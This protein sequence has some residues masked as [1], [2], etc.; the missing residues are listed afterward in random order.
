MKYYICAKTNVGL[1]RENNEDN[2]CINGTYMLS[3]EKEWGAETAAN[4][5]V[6]AVCDGMG[7]EEF[8]EFASLCAASNIAENCTVL[9]NAK[10][11]EQ[12]R[13]VDN[14]ISKI[15]ALICDEMRKRNVRI[16]STVTM[17]CIKNGVAD[18]YNIGDSRIYLFRNGALSQL[19]KDHTYFQQKADMGIK[20]QESD[21]HKLTQN[22]GIFEH[23]MEVQAD[24]KQMPIQPNDV[25]LL[26]SDG[27]TDMVSDKEI[28]Q[29]LS[30]NA[31]KAV[32]KLI[33]T[34]LKNGGRDNVSVILIRTAD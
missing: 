23:E 3:P 31:E 28:Q 2:L 9:L 16:G 21:K 29:I 13:A 4:E 27:L 25:F 24:N 8:G 1:K 22:L 12:S 6:A 19:T 30:D 32:D 10:D 26:C 20:G 17:L 18:I 14:L 33:E 11:G 5:C 15:N 7:G 34:A